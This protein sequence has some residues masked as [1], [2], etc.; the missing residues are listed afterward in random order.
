MAEPSAGDVSCEFAT[1]SEQ[2]WIEQRIKAYWNEIGATSARDLS[3]HTWEL[4]GSNLADAITNKRVVIARK[5]VGVYFR[6]LNIVPKLL[7]LHKRTRME[8]SASVPFSALEIL[9]QAS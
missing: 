5:L 7:G 1:A 4:S 6:A 2:N 8:T 9:I 3:S